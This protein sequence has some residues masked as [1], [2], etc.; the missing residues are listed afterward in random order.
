M[1]A[2]YREVTA[3]GLPVVAH[4]D[5]Y[6]TR[7]DLTPELLARVAETDGIVAVE[8]FSGDVR[9]VAPHRDLCPHVDVL[10]G[11]DDVLLELVLC[12]ARGWV[13]GLS[14]ALPRQALRLYDLCVA[15]DLGRALPLYAELH[16][17]FGWA[18]P[19]GGRTG[20][21][22]WRWTAPDG[23]VAGAARRAVRCPGRPPTGCAGTW[24]RAL[25][26]TVDPVTDGRPR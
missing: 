11:A 1:V 10:A 3:V 17:A 25:S 5:P 16:P 19:A 21:S 2:H 6:D 24:L 12:G 20:R 23:S 15:G 18:L 14:N 7:L 22:S 4:N 8:E 26:A 13:A 9:R